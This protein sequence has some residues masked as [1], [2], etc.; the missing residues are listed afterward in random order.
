MIL[1]ISF[2]ENDDYGKV[3]EILTFKAYASLKQCIEIIVL[4]D[5]KEEGNEVFVLELAYE[6]DCGNTRHDTTV[7]III[8]GCTDFVEI[9][10]SQAV[11]T[12]QEDEDSVSICV[13]VSNGANNNFFKI[14]T[15]SLAGSSNSNAEGK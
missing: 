8:D 2:T 11:Y 3:S 7:V 13:S 6:S 9:S 5:D 12:V 15:S 14:S 4:P 10:F 1:Y